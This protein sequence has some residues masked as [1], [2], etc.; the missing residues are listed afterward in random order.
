MSAIRQVL[1]NGLQIAA[2][3]RER[4]DMAEQRLA[5][6]AELNQE[7]QQHISNLTQVPQA[8]TV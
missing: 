3:A 6:R 1:D 2:A 4:A 7:R 5:Q 8:R